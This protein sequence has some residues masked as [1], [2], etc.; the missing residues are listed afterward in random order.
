MFRVKLVVL[1]ALTLLAVG[2]V[3]AAS[4]SATDHYLMCVEAKEKGHGEYANHECIEEGGSKDWEKA[5]IKVGEGTELGA[6]GG[7]SELETGKF[8]IKCRVDKTVGALEGAGTS[9]YHI[10][11]KSCEVKGKKACTVSNYTLKL[12]GVL[13]GTLIEDPVGPVTFIELALLSG[14][15][16]TISGC[17]VEGTY[18]FKGTQTCK[19]PKLG[20]MSEIHDMICQPSGN[21]IEVEVEKEGVNVM[22]K[23]KF[24]DTEEVYLLSG[25]YWEAEV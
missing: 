18:K 23:A 19:M 8:D 25:L 21:E 4:A 16:V 10:E 6:E 1:G 13:G 5:V 15:E 3:T 24:T 20:E 7:P 14:S 11:P 17:G 9:A 22:E 2:A 12:E